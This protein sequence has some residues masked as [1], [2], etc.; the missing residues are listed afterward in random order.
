MVRKSLA[1]AAFLSVL[2]STAGV[3]AADAEEIEWRTRLDLALEEASI[4]RRPVLVDLYTDWCGWCKVLDRKTYPDPK[5]VELAKSFVSTKINPEK[6]RESGAAFRIRGYPTIL[7]LDRRGAEIGRV[8]GYRD[9]AAFA[10][11]MEA[12]LGHREEVS[13]LEEAVRVSPKDLASRYRLADALL[14]NGEG[15]RARKELEAL[16]RQDPGNARGFADDAALDLARIRYEGGHARGA[17]EEFRKFLVKYPESD[18]AGEARLF[19]ARA[20]LAA[21]DARK[22]REEL[23]K[24]KVEAKDRWIGL[25]AERLLA[26]KGAGTGG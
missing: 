12:A 19:Y 15:A 22:S 5:V 3:S 6:D 25:E 13:E 9:A 18:R 20:L 7:F 10:A 11:A 26:T 17:A 21:G 8:V 24:L 16:A 4:E 2:A 1:I 14:A 23:A